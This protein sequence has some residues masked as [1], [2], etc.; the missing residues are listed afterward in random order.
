MTDPVLA[1]QSYQSEILQIWDTPL[2][3][4]GHNAMLIRGDRPV[5]Q[6]TTSN[7]AM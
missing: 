5:G 1:V 7:E 4:Q 2:P 3:P 6:Y